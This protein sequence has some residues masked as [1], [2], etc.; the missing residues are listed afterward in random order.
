MCFVVVIFQQVCLVFQFW[1]GLIG[2]SFP[3]VPGQSIT[4]CHPWISVHQWIWPLYTGAAPPPPP[5][6]SACLKVRSGQGAP[7]GFEKREITRA[8][9]THTSHILD[10]PNKSLSS[11]DKCLLIVYYVWLTNIVALELPSQP[12][13]GASATQFLLPHSIWPSCYNCGLSPASSWDM[14]CFSSQ[15]C[16]ITTD[17]PNS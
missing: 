6:W 14:Q 2:W 5:L 9:S 12:R 15:F 3:W 16:I 4:P 11:F 7:S 17:N 10:A 8:S 1:V 13:H